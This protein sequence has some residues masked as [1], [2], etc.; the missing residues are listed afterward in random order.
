L[1][2]RWKRQ[3]T[4]TE[5]QLRKTDAR[6]AKLRE[7]ASRRAYRSSGAGYWR[8][9][10]SRRPIRQGIG[11]L[12]S[13]RWRGAKFTE[14]SQDAVSGDSKEARPSAQASG[15]AFESRIAEGAVG[16]VADAGAGGPIRPAVRAADPSFIRSCHEPIFVEQV[17]RLP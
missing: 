11:L 5:A 8:A 6:M 9:D 12:F 4:R 10:P 2:R 17:V 7:E 16:H 15:A 3:A 13:G 14:T 1:W